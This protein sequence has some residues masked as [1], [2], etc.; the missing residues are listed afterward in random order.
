MNTL[1]YS[2]NVRYQIPDLCSTFK[3]LQLFSHH[4]LHHLKHIVTCTM[5][6]IE[7]CFWISFFQ[8]LSQSLQFFFCL[9]S[10]EQVETTNNGFYWPRTC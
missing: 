6:C 7:S 8:F 10:I 3:R 5:A 1:I 2:T 9:L 4:A